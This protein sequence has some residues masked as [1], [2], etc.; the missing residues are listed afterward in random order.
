[1]HETKTG[2]HVYIPFMTY[3]LG[4]I[5]HRETVK[6]ADDCSIPKRP[7]YW[8]TCMETLCLSVCVCVCAMIR[9]IK[10][11]VFVLIHD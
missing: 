7:I 10:Y 9:L 5:P 3:D 8:D 2:M 6:I 11:A 1:M 4:Y